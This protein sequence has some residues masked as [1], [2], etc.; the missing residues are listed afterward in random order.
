M[1]KKITIV[2]YGMGNIYSLYSAFDY[3][4]VKVEITCDPSNISRSKI[5]ILPGVGSFNKA[6]QEIVK[7]NI[8]EALGYAFKKGSY[9]LGICL[10]MQLFGLSSDED[11]K[12]EGLGFIKRKVK[13]FKAKETNGNKIPHVG[14]NQVNFLSKN[15]LF[16]GLGEQRDFY[17]NHS[18][19]MIDN[20][21][22]ENT[23]T[24]NYG[25]NFLSSY[26]N[27]NLYATQF[28][29]EKSQVN[30]LKVLENF[31]NVT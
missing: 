5:I 23:S 3:L 29:P 31:L 16:K 30:G 11:G 14:F 9:L 13:K 2:N 6:M 18:Y 21:L 10:G 25:L 8:D 17:F 20:N 15:I 22:K 27:E 26:Y 19:R 28:H 7:L 12:T 1:K 4:N 24:T